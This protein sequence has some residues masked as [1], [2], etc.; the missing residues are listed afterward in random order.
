MAWAVATAATRPCPL[1]HAAPMPPFQL[2]GSSH[3]AAQ[4]AA[5]AE[6]AARAALAARLAAG[7]ANGGGVPP[8]F[9]A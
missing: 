9:A 4:A 2:P 3:A 6:A 7:A 5:Q 1:P 8:P